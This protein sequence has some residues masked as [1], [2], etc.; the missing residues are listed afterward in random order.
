MPRRFQSTPSRT[1]LRFPFRAPLLRSLFAG[2]RGWRFM[3]PLHLSLVPVKSI[4]IAFIP[5][6]GLQLCKRQPPFATA[7]AAAAL[8]ATATPTRRLLLVLLLVLL[9]SLEPHVRFLLVLAQP[10][11]AFAVRYAERELGGRQPLRCSFLQPLF[12]V[13]V[14]LPSPPPMLTH[15]CHVVLRFGVALVGGVAH[16]FER[17]AVLLAARQSTAAAT[18]V[19][20][21]SKRVLSSY[22]ALLRCSPP[23]PHGLCVG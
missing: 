22:L 7:A 9:R 3:L 19:K 15:E 6:V 20:H 8:A 18:G 13:L 4:P 23:P 5:M 12:G 16:V 2:A 17:K 14:R 11:A 10:E 21:D 1:P